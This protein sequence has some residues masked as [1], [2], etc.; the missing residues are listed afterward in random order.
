MSFATSAL[1]G[2]ITVLGIAFVA[3]YAGFAAAQTGSVYAVGSVAVD[4]TAESAATARDIALKKGQVLAYQRLLDRIVP[5]ND[6]SKLSPLPEAQLL[7]LVSGIEVTKEKTSSVRYLAKLVV[8]FNPSAV[9]SYLRNAGIQFAETES[10]PLIVLPVFRSQATQ[11]LWDASN[12]WLRVWRELPLSDG[13]I[14]LIVPEGATADIA[15]ISAEQAVEGNDERIKSISQRYGA[16]VALLT[17]AT[18]KQSHGEKIVEVSTSRLD[19]GGADQTSVQSFV[20]N[21]EI[22]LQE[23]LAGAAA[24]LRRE[25][26]ENWKLDNLIRFDDRRELLAE[27]S[28]R[29]LP[30]LISLQKKL[31]EV[32]LIKKAELVRLSLSA[33]LIRL[34]Y[35]GSPEQL[36]LALAQ[37]D[38]ALTQGSVY[39]KLQASNQ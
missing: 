6:R 36:K 15:E 1:R 27:A 4:E 25:I 29:G 35:L 18:V 33:A 17:I 39:W 26:E 28:L 3:V 37:H 34:R 19:P 20:S 30:E 8:R 11:Q 38:M 21:K 24:N 5:A 2:I 22:S 23:V 14:N 32:S 16:A 9:R 7:Q 10:K 12:L 31:E 13:L